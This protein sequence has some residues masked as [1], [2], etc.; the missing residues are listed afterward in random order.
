VF[1]RQS[2]TPD[3]ASDIQDA[4]RVI[5]IDASAEQASGAIREQWIEAE[6]DASV[7]MVHFLEPSALLEWCRRTSGKSPEGVLITV[8]GSN[9]EIGETLS[10]E[11][12]QTIP[13]IVKRT[14]ELIR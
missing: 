2:L 10:P 5:F 3:L 14:L 6:A 7:A 1:E 8:G 4:D 9:F 12:Q 11:V 13:A